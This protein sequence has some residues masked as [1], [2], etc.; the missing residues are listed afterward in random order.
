M[1]KQRLDRGSSRCPR[2]GSRGTPVRIQL[3]RMGYELAKLCEKEKGTLAD[4]SA[5]GKTKGVAVEEGP[6]RP[7]FFRGVDIAY[8]YMY[9]Y[10]YTRA[11]REKLSSSV[12]YL[13]ILFLRRKWHHHAIIIGY[14]LFAQLQKEV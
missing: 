2:N 8:V 13:A 3:E 5:R 11:I 9:V 12:A 7:V 6:G 10:S 14:N 4:S 1:E